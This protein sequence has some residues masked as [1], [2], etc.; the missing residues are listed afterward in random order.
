MREER[1][2]VEGVGGAAGGMPRGPAG[3]AGGSPA[4]SDAY[5]APRTELQ[6][7][8]SEAA[9]GSLR[10]AFGK[11]RDIFLGR[12]P[13]LLYEI[14]ALIAQNAGGAIGFL[15]R[16]KL[17]PR[18][19]G[20][21]GRGVVFGKGVIL[22]HPDRIWIGDS[23]VI[24]DNVVLDAK[25]PEG[26]APNIVIGD[27]V[28]IGRNTILSCKGGT[29]EIG[30]N[31]NIGANCQIQSE[32]SCRVGANVLFASY[33]YVVA[34]GNH[35]IDRVDIPPIQQKPVSRGGVRI[36]DGAWLGANVKVIDGVE[37]G[38]DSV[39]A[40][41]AVVIRSCGGWDIVGGVPAK[42]IRNRLE[43]ARKEGRPLPAD[44]D[45][46]R[47]TL[48]TRHDPPAAPQPAGPLRRPFLRTAFSNAA[49][50]LLSVLLIWY[51]VS[52]QAGP[53][54]GTFEAIEYGRSTRTDIEADHPEPARPATFGGRIRAKVGAVF[55][56][57]SPP[58]KLLPVG[59]VPS[60]TS[61]GRRVTYCMAARDAGGGWVGDR[62]GPLVTV[63]YDGNGVA[64][65]K[66]WER[67]FWASVLEQVRGFLTRWEWFLFAGSFH[68]VGYLITSW[69]WRQTI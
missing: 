59:E 28:F 42:V 68:F 58:R 36:C 23:V 34:G 41:G 17:Y 40:A 5:A 48:P 43:E 1:T 37:M 20:R 46:H 39:A 47:L 8:L 16:K 11:Y 29:I 62:S 12:A 30:D 4:A 7:G 60:E 19:L 66:A 6:A 56:M 18:M 44:L 2:D 45:P 64:V 38:R 21:C 67:G 57:R 31:A 14:S 10:G 24:D 51:L 69:N 26:E 65:R 15:L 32:S 33:C 27:G 55:S 3:P 50:V 35:G 63:E 22:R 49:K 61:G 13:F 52:L 25:G 54:N 9:G 53:A